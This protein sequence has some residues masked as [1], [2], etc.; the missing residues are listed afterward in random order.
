MLVVSIAVLDVGNTVVV[1]SNAVLVVSYGNGSLHY[2]S[3]A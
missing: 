2:D 1:A 3:M